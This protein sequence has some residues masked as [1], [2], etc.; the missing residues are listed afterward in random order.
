MQVLLS[1]RIVKNELLLCLPKLLK[2]AHVQC[3]IEQFF[4][5]QCK[6]KFLYYTIYSNNIK[7]PIAGITSFK[8]N[9]RFCLNAALLRACSCQ[10]QSIC[11]IYMFKNLIMSAEP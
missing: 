4:E 11:I 1:D 3:R 10:Q 8:K 9:G 6:Q 5:T 2:L 7:Q